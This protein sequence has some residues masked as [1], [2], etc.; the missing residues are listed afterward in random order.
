MRIRRT[1]RAEEDL[2]EIWSYLAA[3]N[4]SAADYL[5]DRFEQRWNG[6]LSY[7]HLGKACPDIAEGVRVLVE[8]EHLIYYRVGERD[9]VILR[10][11]H[12]RRNIRSD[13]VAS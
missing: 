5:L 11:L 12:G 3:H 6:L 8:G 13:D 9:I 2:I 1:A 7:P 10:V 4:E